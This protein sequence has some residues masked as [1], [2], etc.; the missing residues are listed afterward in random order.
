[1]KRRKRLLVRLA[2][3]AALLAAAVGLSR[4]YSFRPSAGGGQTDFTPPRTL[5]PNDVLLPDEYEIEIIADG[6]TFPTGIT[7]DETGRPLITEAGYAYGGVQLAPRLIRLE[8][9]GNR[10]VLA[11]GDKNGPW[12]G[13]TFHD[14]FI[15][16]AEGGIREGGRILRFSENGDRQVLI[17]GLPSGDHHTNGPIVGPDG[18]LYFGQGTMT[19]SGVVGPDNA[20]QDWLKLHPDLHDIPGETVRLSGKN[21][22]S[23]NISESDGEVR[24]GA[25]SAFGEKTSENEIREGAEVASGSIVRI[26][27]DGGEPELVA[28]GFRNPF[29]IVFS[30]EGNLFATDHGYDNRGSRPVWGAPDLLWKVEVGAWHG[31]PDFSGNRPLTEDDFR[32]PGAEPLTFLLAE[33]PN[34]PPTPLAHLD[35]HGGASGLD[36][37]GSNKFGF[38]GEIFVAFFG[39]LAPA[40][41]RVL[42]PVGFKI[43]RIDPTTGVFENFAVNRGDKNGPASLIGG[44]GF[45]RPVAVRFDPEGNAL[46]VVD[47]GVLTMDGKK[48][49]PHK[50][51]GVIWKITR[52]EVR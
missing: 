50:E 33:H 49:R 28:W 1:M 20:D 10:T 41:N 32:P 17:S 16:V 15:Y 27:L 44:G 5:D 35:V 8:P 48:H 25:F 22:E 4:C 34:V 30:K 36:I 39:D 26:P 23:A 9:D 46:Y 21:F 29:G 40:V 14:G 38:E 51:T 47:F 19:N 43:V 6:L 13:L 45:E 24:T 37:S 2:I 18:W 42:T 3:C 52:K 7:F 12:N 31:W 11:E